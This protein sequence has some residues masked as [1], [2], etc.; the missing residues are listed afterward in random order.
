MFQ[1]YFCVL[2]CLSSDQSSTVVW[3]FLAST[4]S[5]RSDGLSEPGMN[6][7][8]HFWVRL[9][10]SFSQFSYFLP[11]WNPRGLYQT[12][13]RG[14]QGVS[15]TSCLGIC[16]S[17]SCALKKKSLIVLKFIYCCALLSH[18]VVSDSATPWT[19]ARQAPLS[20]G[21]LQATILEW[22]AMPSSKG[23]SQPSNRTQVSCPAGG[24]FTSWATGKLLSL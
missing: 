23:S 10:P 21:I 12:L 1:S 9:P 7:L 3:K 15:G 20:M 16:Y 14:R 8:V 2:S 13:T 19:A 11:D 24:F 4:S 17:A 5:L 18:S 6:Q 22:I